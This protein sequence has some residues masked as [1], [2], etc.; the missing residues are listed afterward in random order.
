MTSISLTR[1]GLRIGSHPAHQFIADDPDDG[2]PVLALRGVAVSVAVLSRT[3]IATARAVRVRQRENVGAFQDWPDLA[4]P[5]GERIACPCGA[6][7]LSRAEEEGPVIEP[8][9]APP[10]ASSGE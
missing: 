7:H 4:L 10:R 2:R 5:A 8:K 9:G 1:T 3:L 6:A